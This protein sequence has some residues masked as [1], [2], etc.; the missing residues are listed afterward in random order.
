MKPK[1]INRLL[2]APAGLWF[3]AMLVLPLLVVLVF[4]FGERGQA[5]GRH[6]GGAAAVATRPASLVG[7]SPRCAGRQRKLQNP[8]LPRASQS[9]GGGGAARSQAGRRRLR[10]NA[11][12]ELSGLGP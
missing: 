1:L 10:A 3:L 6:G 5:G 7:A 2:L 8:K 12:L 4:S 9:P 11:P